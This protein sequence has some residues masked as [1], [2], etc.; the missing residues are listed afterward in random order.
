ML[1][2]AFAPVT[3]ALARRRAGCNFAGSGSAPR[4][5][6]HQ[7]RWRTCFPRWQASRPRPVA[8]TMSGA[9]PCPPRPG[10]RR[11]LA[12]GTGAVVV[13]AAAGGTG[14]LL[15]RRFSATAAWSQA[16]PPVASAGAAA[17]PHGADL[18]IP[19]GL[20]MEIPSA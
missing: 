17:D 8:L 7:P 18:N 16:R 4:R 14:D 20:P 9:R 2:T 19:H 6:V 1:L 11:F 3:G 12:V 15:L 5:P 10:R 13:A